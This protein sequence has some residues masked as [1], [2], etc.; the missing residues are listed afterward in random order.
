MAGA[1]EFEESVL[2]VLRS[3][4]TPCHDET[5]RASGLSV[6]T[7]EAL[8]AG[9]SR[10]G[11]AV[12]AGSPEQSPLVQAVRGAIE[13][14]MPP[15]KTLPASELAVIEGWVRRLR[16]PAS[17]P[18]D[19]KH[20]SLVRPVRPPVPAVK[21]AG[22][23]R[24]P[25]DAFV[26]SKLEQRRLAPAKEAERGAMA[27][28]L[29]LD[30]LG[31]PPS[32]EEIRQFVEDPSPQAH[33]ALVDRLLG[34]PQYGVRWGRYWLDLARYADTNGY[35]GDPEFF[36][37]WRY[38]DYVVDAFNS[39]KP[40][41]RFAMEQLAGDEFQ[42]VTGAGGLPA[43]NPEQVVALT[44]LR[45]APFTE[46]RGEE[47]RDVL[48]SE[49]TAT[50][51]SVFL[52][53][54]AGCAKCHD[55]K[56]DPI[57]TRDFYRLKAFLAS[58][59]IAPPRP[60]DSQQLG[61]PQPAAFYRPGEKEA[62]DRKAAAYRKALEAEDAAIE[63]FAK[64]LVDRLAALWKRDKPAGTKPPAIRDVERLFNEENNNTVRLDKKDQTFTN[65]ERERFLAYR[66][67][68]RWLKNGLIRV[69]PSA[70]SL[71]NADDPPYGPSVP[72][73]HVLLRGDHDRP[74]EIVEP[75]FPSAI[76]GHSLP[77]PLPIDRYKRHPTRG[78]RLTLAKW[79]AS[80]E[81]PLTA[82]VMVNRIWRHHFGRG[83]VE[84]P[85]DFG[86]NGA[87]PTHPELL[88]WLATAFVERAWSVKAMHRLILNS[89]T[90]RQASAGEAEADQ[91][92]RFYS[93]FPRQRL[94]GEAIRDSVLTVSGRLNRELGGPPI[95]PPLPEGLDREQ[96]VQ[97]N[98]TW[99]TSPEGD[100]LRRSVYVF[101]RR[102]LS[103]PMLEVFDAPVP[104]ASC[105]LRRNTVTALQPLAMYDSEFV[106][107]E[108]R[109][110]AERVRREAGP[111]LRRQIQRAFLVSRGREAGASELDRSLRFAASI[112]DER[113]AITGIC[114]VLI[115]SN[116][117]LYVD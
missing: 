93:S 114:R 2:P 69:E 22:W 74:G 38:R 107:T 33:E 24:N 106:N 52:G 30:L 8:A 110:F 32:P 13:P 103:L 44:F 19:G 92:N 56:Y 68:Q 57:P 64:P 60:G 63:T 102:S 4:C 66:E 53:W 1:G 3:N 67:R 98:N 29:Y 20:W 75:G 28:R 70:M 101:Q 91:G 61:G 34:N 7:A 42:P 65:E 90:Y 77:A 46:P 115:N 108:A 54:T 96:R 9:G 45:L 84:T 83:I 58:V 62:M 51:S 94:T 81:N 35:E 88:D 12:V 15:G 40:Y 105:D 72:V 49:M 85:S 41:D 104:N 27:R 5:N 79:I 10:R 112:A 23:V 31:L 113:S 76:A 39:D 86:R 117:F 80:P 100:A 16:A 87:R 82:R 73:T 111:D 37:A 26:L 18:D 14:R 50:A 116:E 97:S 48:L 25:I 71:R 95:F 99:E 109:H 43:P 59:Y 36:H 55:H 78:R 11:P 89:N 47:S 6:T 17:R 21:G